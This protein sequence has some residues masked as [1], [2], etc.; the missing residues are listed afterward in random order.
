MRNLFQIPVRVAVGVA[1]FAAATAAQAQINKPAPSPHA[2][3]T[4]AVG[5]T[6]VTLDYSRPGV[7]G[8]AIFG[9]L[10]PYGEVWR[11][12]ANGCTTIEFANN[13][14]VAGNEVPAGK[15]SLFT[16]PN[17]GNWTFILNKDTSLWGAGGYDPAKDLMRADVP[18]TR[19]GNLQETMT[20]DFEG[21]HNNGANLTV[22]WENHKISVPIVVESDSLVFADIEAKVVNAT[23]P[24]SP[25]TYFDAAMFY[26]EKG[27]DLETAA[28]WLDKAVEMTP[29][30]FW[31]QYYQAELAF[32]MGN[33]DKARRCCESAMKAA[34]AS[35]TGDYGYGEKCKDLMKQ[36]NGEKAEEKAGEATK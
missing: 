26:Y 15:Y 29:D 9:E 16:I 31:Q 19:L 13:A 33:K 3:L 24:I 23:A 20:I 21:F 18:V 10:V 4:Q 12:G 22:A 11:T 1:M 8:R 5:L 25:R 30:A 27:K 14:M 28:K 2:T 35:K 36:I 32:K 7:K 6:Q 34:A 17:K